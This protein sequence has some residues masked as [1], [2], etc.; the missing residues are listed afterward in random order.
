MYIALH[1]TFFFHF[2]LDPGLAAIRDKVLLSL[3][4]DVIKIILIQFYALQ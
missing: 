1:Y 2:H 3:N 4:Y